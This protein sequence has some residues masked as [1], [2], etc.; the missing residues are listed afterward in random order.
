[1]HETVAASLTAFAFV[2]KSFK[3]A[4]KTLG[5]HVAVATINGV[6]GISTP[7]DQYGHFDLHPYVG[8]PFLTTF[9]V[10]SQIP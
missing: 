3:R 9:V 8:G 4:K 2:E 1:M 6:H 10:N 7:S 5:T